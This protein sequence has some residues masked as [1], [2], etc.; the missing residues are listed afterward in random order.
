ML[1]IAA[2]LPALA[3]GRMAF[4]AFTGMRPTLDEAIERSIA[5]GADEIIVQPMAL[6]MDSFVAQELPALVA[7]YQQIVPQIRF[8][9]GAPLGAHPALVDLVLY[10][11]A[12]VDYLAHQLNEAWQPRYT[13]QSTGIVLFSAV[14]EVALR[15]AQQIAEQYREAHLHVC[16]LDPAADEL[17]VQVGDWV[18]Q[19]IRLIVVL[20]YRLGC[21]NAELAV[22]HQR[23]AAIQAAYPVVEVLLADPLGYDQRLVQTVVDRAHEARDR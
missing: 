3:P 1:R 20:L 9:V 19:G 4:A 11:V 5:G 2:R 22:A 17:I 6:G 8:R 14:P 13:Q 21:T 10:Q 7:R 23:V 15:V 12:S 16:G 18:A